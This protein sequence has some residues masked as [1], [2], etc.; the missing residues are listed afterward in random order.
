MCESHT[1]LP[2]MIND[3]CGSKY[4][5]CPVQQLA[6]GKTKRS[7]IAIGCSPLFDAYSSALGHVVR[8]QSV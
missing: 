8:A 4:G 7:L 6:S 5:V 1:P 3:A 2:P